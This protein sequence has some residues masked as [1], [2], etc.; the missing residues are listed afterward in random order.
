MKWR[1]GRRRHSAAPTTSTDAIGLPLA[2]HFDISRAARDH[3]L[4]CRANRQGPISL[5]V[6]TDSQIRLYV[7]SRRDD[8][9]AVTPMISKREGFASRI[10]GML[11][12]TMASWLCGIPA[13][14]SAGDLMAASAG[15]CVMMAAAITSRL[16]RTAL[17]SGDILGR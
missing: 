7:L 10:V 3:A 14:S 5:V 8:Y 16:P 6:S 15:L 12:L 2:R 11:I 13:R 4:L 17:N 1:V 9:S